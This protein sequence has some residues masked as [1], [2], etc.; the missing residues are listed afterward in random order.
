MKGGNA[1]EM[2]TPRVLILCQVVKMN[3]AQF[4]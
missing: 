4:P 3:N 2:D 1:L